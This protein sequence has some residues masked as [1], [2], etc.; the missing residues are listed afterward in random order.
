MTTNATDDDD[1][2]DDDD[3]DENENEHDDASASG[4][5]AERLGERRRGWASSAGARLAEAPRPRGPRLRGAVGA[6]HASA[7]ER[8][9]RYSY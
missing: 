3:D 6:S 2:N 1:E 5:A 8:G 9:Q 7:G 4:R